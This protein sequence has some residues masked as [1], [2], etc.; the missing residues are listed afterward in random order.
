MPEVLNN[1]GNASA[2]PLL[3]RKDKKRGGTV[4]GRR[5]I[6]IERRA[7]EEQEEKTED[8]T[9]KDRKPKSAAKGRRQGCP[10]RQT[11]APARYTK[12]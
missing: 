11:T 7:A 3:Q 10:N 2:H 1:C 8:A 4:K 12:L 5:H 9:A 6:R